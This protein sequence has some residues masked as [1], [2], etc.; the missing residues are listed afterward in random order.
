MAAENVA[1]GSA[2]LLNGILQ[3]T[4]N[5]LLS[6]DLREF[7]RTIFASQNRVTHEGE[8]SIIRESLGS[9]TE[10]G[11]RPNGRDGAEYRV[12]KNWASD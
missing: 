1:V 6:D 3:G 5:V 4:G 8:V 10:T 11:T 7:L 2:A 12:A 9:G